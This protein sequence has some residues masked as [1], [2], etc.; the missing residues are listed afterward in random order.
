M[1]RRDFIKSAA[2]LALG[3]RGGAA[4]AR[5]SFPGK[6][7]AWRAPAEAGL[8][9]AELRRI[10]DYLGGR[11]MIVRGG[12]AV[13]RWGDPSRAGDVASAAKPIYTHFLIRAVE[14]GKLAGF[15]TRLIEYEPRL[16]NLNPT[17]GYK[18]RR[19]TFR[20]CANQIS[21]YGVAEAPGTAFDYNDFQMALFWDTLFLKV[22][23]ATL[24][25]VDERVM[26]PGLSDPLQCED[27]PSFLA[28]GL[29]DR[30]GRVRISPRDF[31]RFGLL[32]LRKGNWR[33]RQ[34]VSVEHARMAVSRPL[35]L[36]LPRTAGRAAEMI[37]GQRS[38]GSRDVP[39]NQTDHFG[40]YSWLWWVNGVRRSGRRLWPD[41]PKR[42]FTCLGH[43]HGQRGMAAIP[44]WDIVLSWNDTR[45]GEKPWKDQQRD[46]H[47][48]NEVFRL[49][50]RSLG[51]A[52]REHSGPTRVKQ[53][54]A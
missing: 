26:R 38:I 42:V 16:K 32:Y 39:D 45:L 8:R 2:G 43:K 30:P 22:Y 18:D 46:P 41:A 21:C 4:A 19:I 47:P 29:K 40:S 35:P 6:S 34:I 52:T 20:H 15:D 12:W 14:Q 31:C 54:S 33:G 36:S 25:T 11:G 37:P 49:L 23:G 5:E 44:E 13:F 50:R 10:A 1:N 9:K 51:A 28:F 24:K 7:W 17:L 3:L 48:L 53:G 27:S